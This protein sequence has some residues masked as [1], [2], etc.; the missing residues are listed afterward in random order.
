MS[1]V[2]TFDRLARVRLRACQHE[3][4]IDHKA[5]PSIATGENPR[6]FIAWMYR[7][8]YHVGEQP[9]VRPV[10]TIEQVRVWQPLPRHQFIDG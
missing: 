1:D 2:D 3:K 10:R 5:M 4:A 6:S 8:V 7:V 9:S